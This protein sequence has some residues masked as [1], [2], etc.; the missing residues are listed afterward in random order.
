MKKMDQE[1]NQKK[2]QKADKKTEGRQNLTPQER[3]AE[4][5]LRAQT[6]GL[7]PEDSRR[8]R[9]LRAI[10]AGVAGKKIRHMLSA[11]EI[12]LIEM[13][14]FSPSFWLSEGLL[15]AALLAVLKLVPPSGEFLMDYLLGAS[16]AAA[17]M[18]VAVCSD[19]A[20]HISR[21]MAELEQSCYFNLPQIWTLRMILAGLADMAFLTVCSGMAAE[22]TSALFLQICVYVLVPFVLSNVC[23]LLFFTAFRGGS[24]RFGMFAVAFL[25]GTAAFCPVMMPDLYLAEFLWIWVAALLMGSGILAGQMCFLCRKMKRGEM[26]CWN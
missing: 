25:T 3:D 14:Y 5:W 21:R 4:S 7:V 13:Q 24:G 10:K 1:K 8:E 9:A 6:G 2:N 16:V 12:I 22:K 11:G 23:C 17:W 20:R 15:V 18:G 19:L 26:L